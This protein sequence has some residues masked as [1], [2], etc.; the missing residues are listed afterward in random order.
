MYPRIR[1]TWPYL[2]IETQINRSKDDLRKTQCGKLI[3]NKSFFQGK[4]LLNILVKGNCFS[5]KLVWSCYENI[6]HYGEILNVSSK[7]QVL[8]HFSALSYNP[9]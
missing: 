8:C 4:I 3:L 7:I 1:Y 6:R 5:F 9:S 2:Q